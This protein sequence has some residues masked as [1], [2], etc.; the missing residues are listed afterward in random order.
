MAYPFG[1]PSEPNGQGWFFQHLQLKKLISSL[2]PQAKRFTPSMQCRPRPRKLQFEPLE[3]RLLL[4]ADLAFAADPGG[5]DLT[6]RLDNLDGVDTVVIVDNEI[7]DPLAQV[8]ASQALVDT[9][10]VRI[11]GGVGADRL[12][13]DLTNPF[14]VPV[15]FDDLSGG[16]DDHL[17][18]TGA[19]TGH[20]W[21]LDGT[22]AGQVGNVG[23]SGIEHLLGGGGED[24][25]RFA[26]GA[27]VSGSID[28]G[29]GS[30]TL[31]YSA[32][33]G[34]RT[35]DLDDVAASNAESVIGGSG[36]DTLVGSDAGDTWQLDSTDSGSVGGIEF[37]AF[38]NLQG[39]SGDDTVV[40]GDGADISGNL[41]TGA[42]SDTLDYSASTTPVT[43]DL[44]DTSRAGYESVIGSAGA[45]TIVGT[46]AGDTWQITGAGSGSVAGISFSSFENLRGGSGDDSF[47]FAGGSVS[48]I[49]GGG[50]ID[51]LDY[52][53]L[54]SGITV[55][56]A[57]G[58]ADLA[59]SI[60]GIESVLL[61]AGD[62]TLLG[63]LQAV[64]AD[65]GAGSDTLDLGAVA[66]DLSIT[67][68][69][70]GSI[71]A[72]DGSAAVTGISGVDNIVGGSATTTVVFADGAGVSGTI[73]GSA[74]VLDYTAYTGDVSVD[75]EDAPLAWLRL[76]EEDAS[77][78]LRL[79]SWPGRNPSSRCRIPKCR[80][81]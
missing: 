34:S 61:G 10:A 55:D 21:N 49:D 14:I 41:D 37:G 2:L 50:G 64:S 73:S 24:T 17:A 16:D 18:L 7:A 5:S 62:D 46:D 59:G 77:V 52:S 4:S 25:F 30:D 48:S 3:P 81:G 27:S 69:A 58:T 29:G 40:F 35:V 45:D 80:G 68:S 15:R 76:E 43:V 79:R 51:T 78:S 13:V 36:S 33:T 20:A 60:S 66:S 39:G 42:G 23:F 31:D 22:D 26:D 75:L 71:S 8:V 28:A 12:T 65:L 44:T 1:A 74:V 56:L 9:A 63:A 54:G 70:D 67:V 47:V 11:A 6:L 38:E 57:G 19:L 53:A 72:S 32:S